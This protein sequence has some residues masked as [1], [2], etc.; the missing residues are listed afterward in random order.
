MEIQMGKA[1]IIRYDSKKERKE[2]SLSEYEKSGKTVERI[3]L[4]YYGPYLNGAFFRTREDPGSYFIAPISEEE[5]KQII[6]EE[7]AKLYITDT[8]RKRKHLDSIKNGIV[9]KMTEE[10]KERVAQ[11]WLQNTR[12][13][14]RKDA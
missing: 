7:E 1:G 3:R 8:E 4:F 12:Y 2:I 6:P 14:R 5:L 11:Y 13:L 9:N 10:E